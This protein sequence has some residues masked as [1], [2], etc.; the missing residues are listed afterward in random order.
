M[1]ATNLHGRRGQEEL[2]QAITVLFA[3]EGDEALD[4]M[5]RLRSLSHSLGANHEGSSAHENAKIYTSPF[6]E[7][8]TEII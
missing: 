6:L 1:P 4:F 3:Q 2:W 8:I 5:I 7:N